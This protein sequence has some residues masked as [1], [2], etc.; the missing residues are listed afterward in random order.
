MEMS[1][2][3][4]RLIPE[5]EN[6]GME[7]DYDCCCEGAVGLHGRD[8]AIMNLR[9]REIRLQRMGHFLAA[10]LLVLISVSVALLVITVQGG[11]HH[12]SSD[13]KVKKTTLPEC[14]VERCCRYK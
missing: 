6:N 1:D 10:G 8:A 7:E 9:Q 4:G 14:F 3:S 11:R 2:G 13:G 5:W 12:P